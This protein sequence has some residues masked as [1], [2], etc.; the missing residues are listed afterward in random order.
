MGADNAVH[1]LWTQ[2]RNS[3]PKIVYISL[4]KQV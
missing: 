4:T 2:I 1:I 3:Q